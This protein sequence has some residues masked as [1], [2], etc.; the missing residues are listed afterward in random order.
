MIG[1]LKCRSRLIKVILIGYMYRT[2]ARAVAA[3]NYRIDPPLAELH[4]MVLGQKLLDKKPPGK[5]YPDNK[6]PV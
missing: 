2:A 1:I 4:Y 6:P 5:S 3:A